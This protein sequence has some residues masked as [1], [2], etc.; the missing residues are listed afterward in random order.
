MKIDHRQSNTTEFIKKAKIIHDDKYDYSLVDYEKSNKK[1]KII[2][3]KHGEFEQTP[4]GHLSKKGCQKCG[5]FLTTEN[6]VEKAKK[7]TVINMII[8]WLI[9]NIIKLI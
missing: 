6:F 5:K 4:N 3:D 8:L 1:V 9:I 2:C 7:Y